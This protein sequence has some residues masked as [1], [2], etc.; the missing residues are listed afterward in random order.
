MSQ[1]V[2]HDIYHNIL[3]NEKKNIISN[4]SFHNDLS[5]VNVSLVNI[6]SHLILIVNQLQY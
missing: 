3:K 1:Y 5:T 4:M 6:F 2:I